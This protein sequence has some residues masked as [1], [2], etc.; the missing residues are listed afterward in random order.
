VLPQQ[1]P[2]NHLRAIVTTLQKRFQRLCKSADAYGRIWYDFHAM[3]LLGVIILSIHQE[4]SQPIGKALAPQIG[5]AY[6]G[7][8]N[9]I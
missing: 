8:Q 9:V 6:I 4:R 2:I 3:G 7:I 5:F 1:F